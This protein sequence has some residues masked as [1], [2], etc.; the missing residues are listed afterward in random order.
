PYQL[1]HVKFGISSRRGSRVDGRSYLL[2][3][4]ID[5]TGYQEKDKKK[6]R[7]TK[8]SMRFEKNVKDQ[9]RE[10]PEHFIG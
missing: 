4:A 2:S 3:G 8:P 5:G 7:M 6:A 1:V 10:S 9:S